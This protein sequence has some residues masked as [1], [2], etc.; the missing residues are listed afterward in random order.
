MKGVFCL[1]GRKAGEKYGKDTVRK[2]ESRKKWRT[3]CNGNLP[4]VSFP[5][6]SWGT[7]VLILGFLLPRVFKTNRKTNGL[8]E[9]VDTNASSA[10]SQAK[11]LTQ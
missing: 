3:N 2:K 5:Y 11:L 4:C 8:R 9:A 1:E 10:L 7:I 6:S